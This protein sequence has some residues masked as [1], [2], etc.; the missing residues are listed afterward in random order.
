[1][2][3]FDIVCL[4]CISPVHT[5]FITNYFLHDASTCF[6]GPGSVVGIATGY[7]LDSP[8][9]NA[10]GGEIFRTCPD[11]PWGPSTSCTMGAGSSPGVKSG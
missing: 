9:S 11:Q 7:G 3:L 10:G 8:G 4:L 6:C 5:H 1:M 2:Y